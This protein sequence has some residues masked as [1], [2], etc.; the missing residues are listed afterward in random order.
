VKVSDIIASYTDL[1]Q[2][3]VVLGEE[4]IAGHIIEAIHVYA[5]YAPLGNYDDETVFQLLI[6]DPVGR[7][8]IELTLSEYTLIKPLY[9]LYI[10]LENAIALEATR[11]QGL[12][13]YGRS[14]SEVQGDVTQMENDFHRLA[15]VEPFFTV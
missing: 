13:V 15:F 4:A 11:G 2:E 5:G 10:E 1:L 14:S 7:L 9:D 8:D 12:D 6:E 3:G